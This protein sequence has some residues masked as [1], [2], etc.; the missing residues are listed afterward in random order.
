MEIYGACALLRSVAV[1]PERR[2]E[3]LGILLTESMLILSKEL[4]ILR[5]YLLTETASDFFP[6]FGF[7]VVERAQVP[8]TVKQ[9]VEFRSACPD[10]ALAMELILS[11]EAAE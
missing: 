2:G 4:G 6:R 3:G 5:L 1:S 7:R 11:K 10:T 8:E 9:S